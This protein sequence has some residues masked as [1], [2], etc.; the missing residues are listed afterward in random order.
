MLT[1]K[2]WTRISKSR[3]T[4]ESHQLMPSIIEQVL[5][6]PAFKN[7]VI[8]KLVAEFTSKQGRAYSSKDGLVEGG[9]THYELMSDV[10]FDSPEGEGLTWTVEFTSRGEATIGFKTADSEYGE[11]TVEGPCEGLLE[12]SFPEDVLNLSE[13][14][15]IIEKLEIEVTESSP[16]LNAREPVEI[17]EQLLA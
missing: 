9:V 12:I 11:D 7:A 17:D 8:Q 4:L 3:R 13:V 1:L 15:E 2:S 16:T 14:S 10:E 6:S 5:N